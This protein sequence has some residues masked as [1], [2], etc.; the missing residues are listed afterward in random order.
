MQVNILDAK[1]NLSRLIRSVQAGEEVVIANRG[2]PVARLV[3]VHPPRSAA[4]SRP[5][6]SRLAEWLRA[7]PLPAHLVRSH[8]EIDASIR[9]EREAW[10]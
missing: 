1:N 4:E 6:T 3:R 9:R 10:D 8:E 5:R 2:E 7:H